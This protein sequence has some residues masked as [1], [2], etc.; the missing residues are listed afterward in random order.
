MPF[1]K[2]A[3]RNLVE[4]AGSLVALSRRI[5][6]L[7][8][9][10]GYPEDYQ[11]L[12]HERLRHWR[13]E[14]TEPREPRWY[15]L[16]RAFA[17]RVGLEGLEIEQIVEKNPIGTNFETV[18]YLDHEGKP[19]RKGFY[20]TKTQAICYVHL[21]LF[22]PKAQD[23]EGNEIIPPDDCFKRYSPQLTRVEDPVRDIQLKRTRIN[24]ERLRGHYRSDA[25]N[26][27]GFPE[28]WA[29]ESL[30]NLWQLQKT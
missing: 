17:E 11:A 23:L 22:G 10:S 20:R 1:R 29:I 21:G 14:G 19:V 4:M 12:S 24:R 25:D 18:R 8:K 3:L 7:A 15:E 9:E 16:F 5:S 6:R 28:S 2:E 30:L 13:D 26:D 27:S